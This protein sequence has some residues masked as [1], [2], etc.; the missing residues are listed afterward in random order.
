[1]CETVAFNE[2]RSVVVSLLNIAGTFSKLRSVLVGA[3]RQGNAL[4]LH[5]SHDVCGSALRL[6]QIGLHVPVGIV[7]SL[8]FF[9]PSPLMGSSSLASDILASFYDVSLPRSTWFALGSI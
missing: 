5:S 6:T 3:L 4:S 8:P 2:P 1:M 7:F 9:I